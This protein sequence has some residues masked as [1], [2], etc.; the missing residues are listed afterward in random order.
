MRNDFA[1]FILSHG[2][3]KTMRT[4]KTI[5]SCESRDQ[6]KVAENL[7]ESF[8]R[9]FA[10]EICDKARRI[11]FTTLNDLIFEMT[12]KI[13]DELEVKSITSIGNCDTL[14]N[15]CLKFTFSDGSTAQRALLMAIWCCTPA[16]IAWGAMR[17]ASPSAKSLAEP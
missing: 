1:I 14:Q 11:Y 9:M 15:S 7:V 2:R 6:L 3:A 12:K 16:G 10:K 13:Y 5:K 17:L 8:E 4:L